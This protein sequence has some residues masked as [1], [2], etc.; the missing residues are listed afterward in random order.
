MPAVRVRRSTV[1]LT[2]KKDPLELLCCGDHFHTPALISSDRYWTPSFQTAYRMQMTRAMLSRH[3]VLPYSELSCGAWGGLCV[4]RAL[5]EIM[6]ANLSFVDRR[7]E[8]T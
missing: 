4:S 7:R 6:S 5:R 2:T 3:G 1:E 8:L